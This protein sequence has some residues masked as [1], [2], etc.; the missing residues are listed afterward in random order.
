M[1][2]LIVDDDPEAIGTFLPMLRKALPEARV[3][4]AT[5]GS[6]ALELAEGLGQIDV[7][8]TDVVMKG[9][10]GFHLN[11]SLKKQF[12]KMRTIFVTGYDLAE[13]ADRI[14]NHSV[15]QKPVDWTLLAAAIRDDEENPIA[16]EPA[17]LADSAPPPAEIVVVKP[18]ARAG[19][20]L[21]GHTLG[22]YKV[23]RLLGAGRR[24]PVYE[25][26]QIAMD[27]PV[28]L[29]IFTPELQH[30]VEAKLQFM[31]D[32]TAKATVR[33]PGILGVY[34]AGEFDGWCFYSRE[35]V[36]GENLAEMT[37]SGTQ[38]DELM[39][40]RVI[41]GV[42]RAMSSFHLH[43][44]PHGRINPRRIYI[45]SDKRARLANIATAA[46]PE[47]PNAQREILTLSTVM[48]DVLPPN[49]E[50]SPELQKMIARMRIQDSTGFQSWG[51]LLQ[52]IRTIEPK[53]LAK[54]F[55]P[56]E[57][58]EAQIRAFESKHRRRKLKSLAKVGGAIAG[59]AAVVAVVLWK[60]LVHR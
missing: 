60:F 11:E 16:P 35:Y 42:A 52:E 41:S 59:G 46:D 4:G 43:Q 19:D 25:G 51:A 36:D 37:A 50:L 31:N 44:I 26:T 17:P 27:R 6:E 7:L 47:P 3:D 29:K 15:L 1:N 54:T 21:T 22:G 28:A 14:G 39:T 55:K 40:V 23:G 57:E 49:A 12:P 33:H 18:K 5:D 32:A 53:V 9:V 34:E 2:V 20:S 24:G 8:V 38:L 48:T 56:N 10:D 13:Y 30:D 58:I 45:G